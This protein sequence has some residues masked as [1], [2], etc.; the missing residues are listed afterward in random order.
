MEQTGKV[1]SKSLS[2]LPNQRPC[3]QPA[4]EESSHGQ[5][6][7]AVEHGPR[8]PLICLTTPVM[9]PRTTGACVPVGVNL[10]ITL[11]SFFVLPPK[12][13]KIYST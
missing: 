8:A 5:P 1:T 4:D 9:G 13:H 11:T 10:F 3:E 7:K 6:S 12:I 2:H